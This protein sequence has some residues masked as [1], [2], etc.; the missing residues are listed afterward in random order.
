MRAKVVCFA[1]AKGGTGKTLISAT[2]AKLLAGLEKRVLLMDVDAATNGL[3]LFYLDKLV[4]ARRQFA[5][6][7]TPMYGM[8]EAAESE[9]PSP[10][11]FMIDEATEMIPATYVMK[12]IE[13]VSPESFRGLISRTIRVFRDQYDYIILDAQAGSD[14]YAEIAMEMADEVVVVSEYDPISAQGVD[15]LRHLFPEALSYDRTWIL[16]NKVLPEFAKSLSE[17]L[18]AVRYLSPVPW[19]AQVVRA[20]ARRRLAIDMERGND[21]TLAVMQTV[22]SLLGEEIEVEIDRWKQDK[23][24]LLREPIRDQLAAIEEEIRETTDAAIETEYKLRD[25]Q[26]R[27][28]RTV[29]QLITLIA[30]I[31]AIQVTITTVVFQSSTGV[32]SSIVGI[33]LAICIPIVY[34]YSRRARRRS[35][36]KMKRL[37]GQARAIDLRLSDLKQRREKYKTLVEFDLE[38]FLRKREY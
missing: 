38:T 30:A 8:F 6:R 17:F 10:T 26:E 3:S 33:T 15:R 35:L 5:E 13:G 21:H 4:D 25:V 11:P 19:D 20:F 29:A 23:E 36:E 34:V 7:D 24:K 16:F 32:L 9:L 2:I 14:I 37:Q 28:T 22:Q 31:I 1:S 18:S 27:P 12:Q